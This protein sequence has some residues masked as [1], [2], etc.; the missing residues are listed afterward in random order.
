[1]NSTS[2]ITIAIAVLAVL[3][4]G[5]VLT[6]TRRSDIKGVGSLSRE[7]RKRDRDSAK[8]AR[9]TSRDAENQGVESRSAVAVMPP[10]AIEAWVA[11]DADELGET[12]RAFLNRATV[13]LM[14]ASLGGFAAALIA[15]LWKGAEG[16]FGS[17]ISAGKVDDVIGQIRAADGFLYLPEARSWITEY[18][19][20]AISKAEAAYGGQGAV[21]SGMN[22]GVVALYQKCPHLGCRVPEC[23]TSQWFE[24]PCHGSQYNRVGE[25]KGGPAPRGMDRFGV[26]VTNG[27]IVID[28]GTV[29]GGPPIGTNTTGQ[30]A[31]GPNCVGAE[32][33]H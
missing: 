2:I 5:V 14:S 30:E 19:K 12:R 25:K 18:P 4:L 23:K 13:T 22:A 6:A 3:G 33:S 20:E 17:K 7:T 16:G 21:F 15:F 31:E 8:I 26:S 9:N 29:F 10:A 28:T 11:P 24:C 1:M 32:G 27:M